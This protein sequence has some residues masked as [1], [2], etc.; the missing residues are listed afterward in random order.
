M[1][2]INKMTKEKITL[3][4]KKLNM[5]EPHL[6]INRLHSRNLTETGADGLYEE[7]GKY[8]F[9]ELINYK[10]L[11]D[12]YGEG[13]NQDL[14]FKD[15]E[16]FSLWQATLTI[17]ELDFNPLAN[18]KNPFDYLLKAYGINNNKLP[19]DNSMISREPVE[20]F[21]HLLNY[22]LE[23]TG[24]KS[25]TYRILNIYE[26]SPTSTCF[27]LH[28][29]NKEGDVFTDNL[30]LHTDTTHRV[31]SDYRNLGGFVGRESLY[32]VELKRLKDYK[33]Y[34][35]RGDTHFTDEYRK[36]ELEKVDEI[37]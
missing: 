23:R 21:S 18:I 3:I 31:G 26:L 15:E 37:Y 22:H 20:N 7:D 14:P 34:L 19:R 33:K 29:Y 25:F 28:A 32:F 6:D 8:Y 17:E 11:S 5:R 12:S 2:R 30:V 24:L 35:T 1:R 27:K 9:I 36:E 4:D 13:D 16:N 10:M